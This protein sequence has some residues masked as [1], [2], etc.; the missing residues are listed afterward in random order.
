GGRVSPG[1]PP[2]V[3]GV[4]VLAGVPV[5]AVEAGA[6]AGVR[7][8]G[9]SGRVDGSGCGIGCAAGGCTAGGCVA[10]WRGAG[11]VLGGTVEGC[12]AGW[13]TT[14]TSNA[15]GGGGAD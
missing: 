1:G 7:F 4:S 8:S 10:G 12:G 11:S 13:S 14:T 3:A 15:A 9:A 6:P 5:P 2:V